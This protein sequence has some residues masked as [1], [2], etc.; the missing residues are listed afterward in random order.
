MENITLTGRFKC[1]KCN[2]ESLGRYIKWYKKIIEKTE[3]YQIWTDLN[4]T[5]PPLFKTVE[6]INKKNLKCSKCGYKPHSFVE[7]MTEG[8]IYNPQPINVFNIH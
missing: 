3:K 8:K 5:K 6:E 2:K 4:Y 1:P 7:F